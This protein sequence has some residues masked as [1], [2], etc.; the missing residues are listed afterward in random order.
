[1]EQEIKL[2]IKDEE[3]AAQIWE[4]L[5]QS[6]IVDKSTAEKLVLKAVYFDTEDHLL[7]KNDIALRVRSEGETSFA[8]LKWGGKAEGGLHQRN[9]VNIPIQG[10]EFFMQPPVDLFGESKEGV[11]LVELV[12]DR[13]LINLLEMRFLR[14]RIRLNY[15]GSLIEASVDTGAII[16]DKGECPICEIEFELFAGDISAITKLGEEFVEKYGLEPENESKF[17]RGIKLLAS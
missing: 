5:F 4:D 9:E 16:T 12:G 14:S 1:M 15:Q 6:E 7:S 8:T 11:D 17:A 10:E 13:N 2:S 3:K